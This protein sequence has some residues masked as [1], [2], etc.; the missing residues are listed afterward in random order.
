M[1][2]LKLIFSGRVNVAAIVTG[3]ICIIIL[4]GVDQLNGLLRKHVRKIPIHIP[5]QLMYVVQIT[6]AT[7]E[8]FKV[9]PI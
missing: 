5:A 2:Y 7:H 3:V 4:I 6:Q 8:V 1:T 9:C